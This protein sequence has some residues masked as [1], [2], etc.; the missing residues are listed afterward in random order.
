[1]AIDHRNVSG[2]AGCRLSRRSFLSGVAAAG[3]GSLALGE[4]P[5]R[6]AEEGAR[7]RVRLVFTYVP[8]TGPVWPHIGFD[9]DARKKDLAEKLAKACPEIE[10]VPATAMNAGE[11]KKVLEEDPAF[12]GLIVWAIGIWSDAP[13]ALLAAGKPAIMVDDLYGGSGQFLIDYAIAR[14][15][16][17]KVA[18][19]SSSRLEDVA[20]AAR[21][22]ALLK[23]GA[24]ADEFVAACDEKRKKATPRPDGLDV[25]PDQ[26]KAVDPAECLRRLKGKKLLAV[27]GG[28]GMP[29][30]GKAVEEVLGIHVVPV[31]FP[32]LHGA[33]IRADPEEAARWAA[34]WSKAA[35]R[36][37][38][39]TA[40]DLRK[41]GAMYVGMK[42][43]MLAHGAEG[44]TINCL[45][46]FYG[47]HLQAYPCLGF[48][49]MND[50]GLVGGCEGDI[51]SAVTMLAI[52]TL[53]GRP[54]FISDPVIDTS[55]N[56]IIYAHCVAPTK[57]FGPKGARN[58]F[59]IRSHSEDRKGAVVRSILPTGYMTTTLEVDCAKKE[60][61]LHQ[62]K[63]VD[64]VDDEKACRSKLAAE[65]KGDMD[66]LLTYWDQWGWHR[67]TFYGD[68]K[69]QIA[70]F[71]KA[72]GMKV[73]VEA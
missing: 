23:K 41:C 8:S 57:V 18:G 65:V 42:E 11:A 53:T 22:F 54:G 24:T 52:G 36:V 12:D 47:N 73:I 20:E 49:E 27:G 9:F 60:I 72:T 26:V 70:E 40:E 59:H 37:I 33:Y 31:E 14:R 38:E 62:G 50:A 67:V 19:V 35:E 63:A 39:P 55:K 48:T 7:A 21:C 5:A 43:V 44:I 15:A 29:A 66:R 30:S 17:R 56:Q 3:V 28:W 46:G 71:A 1:M 51:L 34:S 16:G 32:E 13:R 2:C 69:G 10:I 61:L 68:L 4:P 6:A 25:R 45:G 64:N 58:A